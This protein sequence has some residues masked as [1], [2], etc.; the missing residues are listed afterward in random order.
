MHT[1]PYSTD[2]FNAL[3]RG[4]KWWVYLP[5]DIYEF[6]EELTCDKTCSDFAK[7]EGIQNDDVK[8]LLMANQNNALWYAHILP[9]IR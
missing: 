6:D 7:Y 5:S 9:Q 3:L 2:A 1:D 8:K 4:H